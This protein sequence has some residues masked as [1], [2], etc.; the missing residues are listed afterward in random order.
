MSA[1]LAFI[2]R[3]FLVISLYAFVFW[4]FYT[5]SQEIRTQ[6]LLLTLYKKPSIKLTV[7]D[8]QLSKIFNLQKLDIGRDPSNDFYLEDE[9]VSS[10]HTR[11][12]FHQ[13][14]WWIDDLHSTNGTYLNEELVYMATVVMNGDIIRCGKIVIKISIK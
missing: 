5:L 11:L 8:L 13:N 6:S 9:T 7:D 1:V 2:L 3:L 4:A 12:S 10:H 14:Q